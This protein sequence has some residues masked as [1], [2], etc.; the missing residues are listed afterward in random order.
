[1]YTDTCK[2][3]ET[4]VI[5]TERML[6]RELTPE[7]WTAAVITLPDHML[8]P[9]M[10]FNTF[11]ELMLEK[12]KCKGGMTT[13]FTS[14]RLFLM[15]EKSTGLTIGRAGFHNWQARHNR[16]ELGYAMCLDHY[17]QKGYMKEA[18]KLIV[19][20]GFEQMDL[21]RIESFIGPGNTPS[22]KLAEGLGFTKEGLLRGHYNKNGELQD[23][24]CYGLLRHEYEAKRAVT[25]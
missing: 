22:I 21:N 15:V 3:P 14:F 7:L 8:M 12:E 2:P 11:A 24:A 1:M 19:A 18:L 13:F 4:V 16:A 20:Y 25:S 10:G 9:Y 6:L 17:R 5:E 23:S